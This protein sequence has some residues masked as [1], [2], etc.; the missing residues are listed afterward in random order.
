MTKSPP[1]LRGL[2]AGAVGVPSAPPL[3]PPPSLF[4]F[5]LVGRLE[6]PLGR[7][8]GSSSAVLLRLPFSP[9]AVGVATPDPSYAVSSSS[10]PAVV[11]A[12]VALADIPARLLR[13]VPEPPAPPRPERSP[14]DAP[15][16]PP[17]PL[18]APGVECGPP[19]ESSASLS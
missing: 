4:R 19:W 10:S 6:P 2:L 1:L 16:R 7:Y 17:R 14:L 5:F 13:P 3:P 18:P 9:E 8:P 12:A 11:K 15:P